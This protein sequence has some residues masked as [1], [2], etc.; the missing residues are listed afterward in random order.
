[1]NPILVLI[2]GHIMFHTNCLHF[3]FLFNESGLQ[4]LHFP[5]L[6]GFCN[7]TRH[8]FKHSVCIGLTVLVSVCVFLVYN[9]VVDGLSAFWMTVFE[10]RNGSKQPCMLIKL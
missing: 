8:K 5:V 7:L 1:M 2:Y 9:G 10:S 4:L 6:A 3:L